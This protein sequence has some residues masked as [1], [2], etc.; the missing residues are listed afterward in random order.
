MF[1]LTPFQ[2][3]QLFKGW[4]D[5]ERH[6]AIKRAE[7]IATIYNA[8]RWG[9]DS[10]VVEIGDLLPWY[11]DYVA[12]VGNGESPPQRREH[13]VD[14]GV[15]IDESEPQTLRITKRLLADRG[16]DPDETTQDSEEWKEAAEIA[17]R[18]CAASAGVQDGDIVML[19]GVPIKKADPSIWGEQFPDW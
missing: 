5:R 7:I 1:A 8:N 4:E 11:A 14:L 10:K 16:F 2:F 9:E 15:Q 18:V 3:A 12:G 17:E 6:D 19:Q 13:I